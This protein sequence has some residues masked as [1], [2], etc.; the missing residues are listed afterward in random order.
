MVWC[1]VVWYSVVYVD[2]WVA[3]Y[4]MA[5]YPSTLSS[6][7]I[8]RG[9]EVEMEANNEQRRTKN[10][11]ENRTRREVGEGGARHPPNKRSMR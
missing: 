3:R 5:R 10:V 4:T 7:P 6:V 11:P 2:R 8:F 1:G 9:C